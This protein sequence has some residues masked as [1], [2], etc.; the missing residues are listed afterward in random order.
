MY[1]AASRCHHN[2][3]E[4]QHTLRVRRSSTLNLWPVSDSVQHLTPSSFHMLPRLAQGSVGYRY[5]SACRYPSICL[6]CD[7][8]RLIIHFLL[9]SP[10]PTTSPSSELWLSH[11][12]NA[13]DTPYQPRALYPTRFSSTARFRQH[14]PGPGSSGVCHDRATLRQLVSM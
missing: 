11:E 3:T 12:E 7:C 9:L 14:P 5:L 6:A 13:E 10:T 2:I 1:K 8:L 4:S